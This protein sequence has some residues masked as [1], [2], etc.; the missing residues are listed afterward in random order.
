MQQHAAAFI[1]AIGVA[2]GAALPEFVKDAFGA[3]L[4]CDILAHGIACRLGGRAAKR[5]RRRSVTQGALRCIDAKGQR[6]GGTPA[7][8]FRGGE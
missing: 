4:E 2:A 1:A 6:A 3:L 7:D 8:G 5:Y